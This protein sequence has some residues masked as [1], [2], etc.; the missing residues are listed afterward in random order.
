MRLSRLTISA[1]VAVSATAGAQASS[2]LTGVQGAA[3][4]DS[5]ASRSS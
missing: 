5:A 1:L 2:L 4:Q 3:A